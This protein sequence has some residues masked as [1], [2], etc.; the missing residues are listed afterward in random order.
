MQHGCRSG[1]PCR[2][3]SYGAE[4][5][6]EGELCASARRRQDSVFQPSQLS[7]LLP[8][9]IYPAMCKGQI[10]LRNENMLNQIDQ[11]DLL[12]LFLCTENKSEHICFTVFNSRYP[13]E[14]CS[15]GFLGL[16]KYQLKFVYH[17]LYFSQK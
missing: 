10:I 1:A 14:S 7:S 12:H 9:L 15:C 3:A 11:G 16:H 2:H 13:E 4:E 6:F 5:L 17:F 8:L